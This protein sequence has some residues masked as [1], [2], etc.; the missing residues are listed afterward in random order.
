MYN[1]PFNAYITLIVIACVIGGLQYFVLSEFQAKKMSWIFGWPAKLAFWLARAFHYVSEW[2]RFYNDC[3]LDAE[4]LPIGKYVVIS[5]HEKRKIQRWMV[6]R[7]Q[8]LLLGD[9][10]KN[11]RVF[12]LKPLP[13]IFQTV[14]KDGYIAIEKAA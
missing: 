8:Y 3:V 7:Y 2:L 12:S 6:Y 1:L 10:K 13:K 5:V 9:N 11:W 4:H 14:K